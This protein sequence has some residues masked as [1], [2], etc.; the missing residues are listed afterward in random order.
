MFTA[1]IVVTVLAAAANAYAATNDL[2]GVNMVVDNMARLGVPESQLL[3]LAA[4]KVAGAAGLL[5]GIAVP[6]IGVAAA[7]GLIL[8]FVGAIATAIR[9]HWYTHI[10]QPTAFLLLAVG[11]L[12]LRLATA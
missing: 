10:P 11:S 6:V 1:Y 8:F 4:L 9:A 2:L 7:C 5:V 12:A 3:S